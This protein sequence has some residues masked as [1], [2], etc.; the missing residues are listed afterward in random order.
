MVLELRSKGGDM[1]IG[2]LVQDAYN[3]ERT[4]IIMNQVGVVDRWIV[5]WSRGSFEAYWS[6]DLEVI[7][8][9]R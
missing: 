7:S 8:E 5:F 2:D 4:G 3:P 1:K 6:I 9:S